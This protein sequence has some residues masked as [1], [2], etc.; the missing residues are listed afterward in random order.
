MK[1]YDPDKNFPRFQNLVSDFG[2]LAS[3]AA[4]L[5]GM[6]K[7]GKMSGDQARSYLIPGSGPIIILVDDN[8]PLLLKPIVDFPDALNFSRA[9]VNNFESTAGKGASAVFTTGNGKKLYR[10]GLSLLELL[11]TGHLSY[12][13][14]LDPDGRDRI[15]VFSI[16]EGFEQDVYGGVIRF[17]KRP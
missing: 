4:I 14:L 12:R 16:L 3:N 13:F 1:F 2:Q 17:E 5:D 7:W 10:V 11:I 15:K 6:K 9:A 8:S